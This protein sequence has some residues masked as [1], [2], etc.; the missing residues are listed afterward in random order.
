MT[1]TVAFG[2][3]TT[4]PPDSLIKD[5]SGVE[6]VD[7]EGFI[8]SRRR[9]EFHCSRGL[10][11]RLTQTWFSAPNHN[12]LFESV[13]HDKFFT[14]VVVTNQ[15]A[16]GVDLESSRSSDSVNRIAD[17][18]FPFNEALEIRASAGC[19]RFLQSW[20]LKESWAKCIG[21]SIMETCR[22]ISIQDDG[23]C[24]EEPGARSGT[25]LWCLVGVDYSGSLIAIGESSGINF[26]PNIDRFWVVGLS[27]AESVVAC[28]DIRS[29]TL[30]HGE[31]L[32]PFKPVWNSMKI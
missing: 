25:F 15:C 4:T 17:T 32:T 21:K 2:D 19:V 1:I 14:V 7:S 31:R 8:S 27:F 29:F 18:W 9:R 16:V 13:A 23:V 11:A 3:L 5:A 30:G 20:V 10:L 12:A 22:M 24:F 26:L 28:T 6:R